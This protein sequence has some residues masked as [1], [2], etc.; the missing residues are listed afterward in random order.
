MGASV[1]FSTRGK[2]Q[3]ASFAEINVTP[4]VDVMLVL[5]VIFMVT[6]PM[7]TTGI[8]LDLPHGDGQAME[9]A[10]RAIDISIDAQSKIYLGDATVQPEA[11]V[12]KLQAMQKSNPDLKIVISGDRATSYGQVIE[13][14]SLL[15]L[16]GI[17]KVG[18]K[19]GDVV[20]TEVLTKK[21]KAKNK[22]K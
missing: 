12:K 10:D 7:M 16:A 15:R 11:L 5:L 4:F 2:R 19:T 21:P 3:K 17:S 13:L 22:K 1:K 6:A 8:S 18:L 14:M 20:D 9:E